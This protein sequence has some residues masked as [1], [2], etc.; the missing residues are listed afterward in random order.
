M[1]LNLLSYGVSGYIFL[2]FILI[3]VGVCFVTITDSLEGLMEWL[4]RQK[5]L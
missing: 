2:A 3:I 5:R 4:K 1:I